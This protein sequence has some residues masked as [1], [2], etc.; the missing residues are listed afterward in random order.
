MTAGDVT[1]A[2]G[3]W[4]RVELWRVG[5]GTVMS[6]SV[7]MG[8]TC[9][10]DVPVPGGGTALGAAGGGPTHDVTDMTEFDMDRGVFC[11]R[12]AR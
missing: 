1:S 4:L 10:D 2:A 6:G 8:V 5:G 3:C 9:L 11:S 12:A 7:S